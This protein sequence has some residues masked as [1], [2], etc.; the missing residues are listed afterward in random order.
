[1]LLRMVANNASRT[2]RRTS[3]ALLREHRGR[4]PLTPSLAREVPATPVSP[5]PNHE[6]PNCNDVA[7][8]AARAPSPRVATAI[9][10]DRAPKSLTR[11]HA[12]VDVDR[13]G[14]GTQRIQAYT[15]LLQRNAR[16]VESAPQPS[17][18]EIIPLV[19][20]R[21]F[22]TVRRHGRRYSRSSTG[23]VHARRALS[24]GP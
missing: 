16:G 10:P 7:Y 1:M 4:C 11:L 3:L 19:D 21:S 6:L 14:D 5:L 12:R 24:S 9:L 22:T 8:P 20:R 17:T 18:C 23:I 15:R 13:P 2:S